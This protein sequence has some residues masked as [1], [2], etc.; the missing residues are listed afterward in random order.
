MYDPPDGHLK[1]PDSYMRALGD[2]S[3]NIQPMSSDEDDTRA[4]TTSPNYHTNRRT[5]QLSTDFTCIA[6]LHGR[7]LVVLGSNS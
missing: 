7:S 6:P 4:V 1:N 2:G 5:F 3:R